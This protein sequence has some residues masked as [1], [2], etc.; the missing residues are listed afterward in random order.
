[1]ITDCLWNY[2][3][4][5]ETF[6]ESHSIASTDH[7]LK[8]FGL[9]TYIRLL[10]DESFRSSS[11]DDFRAQ[12]PIHFIGFLHPDLHSG[13]SCACISRFVIAV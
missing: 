8:T 6:M 10:D 11:L 13:S 7:A 5:V 9:R 2:P 4:E 12:A 3:D 1:M